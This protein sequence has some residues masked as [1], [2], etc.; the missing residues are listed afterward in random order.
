MAFVIWLLVSIAFVIL[1]IYAYVSKK[2]VAFGFWANADTFSVNDIRAYNC[3]VGKLW[4][5]FG[6]VFAFL[7]L[8]L[9]KGQNNPFIILSILGI[10]LE[11]IVTMVIC[12]FVSLLINLFLP[13][14]L[15][16]HRCINNHSN[17]C[18]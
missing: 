10:M 16:N 7:G 6:I 14:F 11:A 1:G 12:P 9:L 13:I 2:E 17:N 18:L 5:V 3:A 15:F 8:P 4:I